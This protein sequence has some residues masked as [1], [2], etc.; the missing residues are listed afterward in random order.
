MPTT[1]LG[2]DADELERIAGTLRSAA[3]ELDGHAGSVTAT[4]RAVAW[5]GGVATRFGSNWHGGH[6]P[7]I[8]STAQYVRDAAAQLDRNAAEQRRASQVAGG[9]G[10][11]GVGPGA[12][13]GDAPGGSSSSIDDE[14]GS[15]VLDRL[16][17]LLATLGL[18]R[19]VLE[20]LAEH[21]HILEGAGVD[22]L[23]DI[24][25][26]DDFV[27]LLSGLDKVLDV[28]DVVVNLVSDFVEHPDLP[29]DDRIV[30]A[31]ADAATRF[32]I[33]QGVEYAANF[34]AQA[35]TT[36]LLPGLGAALAPFAG[37]A[38]GAIADA[39]IGEIIDAVDGATD[40]VDI[41]ADAAVEAYRAL[42]DTFGLVL[43]AAGAVIDV[44]GDAIDLAGDAAG[45]V[46]DAGG[47]VIGAGA[48]VV[49]GVV[50]S[51]NP[52]D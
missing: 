34:L 15:P 10:P 12:P 27:A 47:A 9:T 40:F 48:D 2:A 36:A 50:G 42:K 37:Q 39:V 29:F 33:D 30:H 18:G 25:T 6:R 46:V 41:A 24:L 38:A 44:A 4:L 23:L 8:A 7:R 22:K 16:G 35:A 14:P 45:A 52:F 19:D 5:V 49:G 17:E 21:A 26:N 28:G 32:G 11:P 43:D 20:A 13:T 51:L 3:D 1:L 31:L